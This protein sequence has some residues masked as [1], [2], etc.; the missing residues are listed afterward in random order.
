[1]SSKKKQEHEQYRNKPLLTALR[2]NEEDKAALHTLADYLRISMGG[3]V[4]MLV[5]K[6]ITRLGLEVR[7]LSDFENVRHRD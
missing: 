4:R 2:M 7:P 3:V 1:M 6:E 5:M